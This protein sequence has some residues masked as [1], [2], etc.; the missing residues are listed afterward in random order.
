MYKP[1]LSKEEV[2]L[3]FYRSLCVG[4]FVVLSLFLVHIFDDNLWMVSLAATG[5]IAFAFPTAQAVKTR[6]I[7]GGYL[8]ACVVGIG[9]AMLLLIWENAHTAKL[10]LCGLAIFI[11]TF[12]MTLLDVE[13]PPAAALSIGVVAAVHPV[14]LALAS[15]GCVVVL[16]VIKMPIARMV[17]K[18]K[19]N[20]QNEK[21]D[22]QNT[23]IESQNQNKNDEK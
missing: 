13:H 12:V 5:F 18:E 23:N 15:F 1:N 20:K 11:T 8:I 3:C 6:V 10:L 14:S 2:R 9:C 17:L 22:E 16:C 7:L 4:I 21:N 19:K